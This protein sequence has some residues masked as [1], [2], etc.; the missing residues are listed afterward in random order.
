MCVLDCRA[1]GFFNDAI[2]NFQ[3]TSYIN[4]CAFA[5]LSRFPKKPH[6]KARRNGRQKMKSFFRNRAYAS[7]K[8][9][10]PS[11]CSMLVSASTHDRKVAT[12]AETQQHRKSSALF[13]T[14]RIKQFNLIFNSNRS[15]EE[16][17]N[18]KETFNVL[19]AGGA[20]I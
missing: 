15:A 4:T 20:T 2:L 6:Q 9:F 19:I 10:L 1:L 16:T 7:V 13:N 8:R 12:L 18:R 14:Q 5:A 11:F 3:P 17:V